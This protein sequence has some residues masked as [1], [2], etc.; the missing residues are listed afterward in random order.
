MHRVHM[1]SGMCCMLCLQIIMTLFCQASLLLGAVPSPDS[2]AN[3]VREANYPL[4]AEWQ[5]DKLLPR[6]TKYRVSPHWMS[7]GKRFWYW[8]RTSQGT[9]WFL[10]DPEHKEKQT[11]FDMSS[12][13][14]A[15]MG[16]TGHAWPVDGD[17]LVSKP[18]KRASG[19][20]G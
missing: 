7:D 4:F 12:L 20:R 3:L 14:G 17:R 6:L 18:V 10:V 13:V 9:Q 15:V 1:S 8:Y 5:D 16:L 2:E 11:L 19:D